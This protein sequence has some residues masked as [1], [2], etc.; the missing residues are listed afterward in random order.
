MPTADSYSRLAQPKVPS[1]LAK[2]GLSFTS[3]SAPT[4]TAPRTSTSS[5]SVAPL[6]GDTGGGGGYTD[7]YGGG[8]GG[9]SAPAPPPRRTLAQ[10]ID[11][12]F[13]L[14][15]QR[16]ENARLEAEY[17]AETER[18][19]GETERE[20]G[21]RREELSTDLEDM[22]LDSSE[23]LAARGLLHSGGLFV[24]QDKINAEGGRRENSIADMLTNLLSSRGQGLLGVQAQGRNALNDR[25]NQI[26]QQYGMGVGGY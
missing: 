5:T 23:S 4:L 24:N 15:Q 19:R 21:V 14:R 9:Y 25:I 10:V 20:Q 8:Y 3:R 11:E 26:T 1:S 2:P 18:L 12:D 22:T 17:G 16:D 13:G 7:N 6:A